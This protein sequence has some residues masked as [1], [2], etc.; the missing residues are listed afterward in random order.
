MSKKIGS[1]TIIGDMGGGIQE[2]IEDALKAKNVDVTGSDSD[3]G[4]DY[5]DFEWNGKGAPPKSVT[6]KIDLSWDDPEDEDDED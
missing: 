4:G 2:D 5:L 1:L 6:I 3:R